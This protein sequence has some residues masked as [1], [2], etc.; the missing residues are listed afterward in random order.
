[1]VEKKFVRIEKRLTEKQNENT[2]DDNK[3]FKF[4]QKQEQLINILLNI[5]E[6]GDD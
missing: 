6:A 1:M 5:K 3:A 4:T 2:S